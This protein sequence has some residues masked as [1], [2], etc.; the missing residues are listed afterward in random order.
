MHRAAG[1]NPGRSQRYT[2]RRQG[3]KRESVGSQWTDCFRSRS[4]HRRLRGKARHRQNRC[5]RTHPSDNA[6]PVVGDIDGSDGIDSH[7]IGPGKRSLGGRPS[8][9]AI[10]SVHRTGNGSDRSAGIDPSDPVVVRVRNLQVPGSVD[11]YPARL[12]EPRLGGRAPVTAIASVSRAGDRRDDA[13]RID[14]ADAVVPR[15][16]YIQIPCR[17]RGQAVDR[18]QPGSPPGPRD[19]RSVAS[20]SLS[21]SSMGTR[22]QVG[23]ST[24]QARDRRLGARA[25]WP[26]Q[27]PVELRFEMPSITNPHAVRPTCPDGG[28]SRRI[29]LTDSILSTYKFS[30]GNSVS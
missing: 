8:V 3:P 28:E 21:I 14:L 15:V 26:G 16:G 22:T 25:G 12:V 20:P 10:A 19:P 29:F 13:V 11:R 24:M 9:S 6:V 5:V 18:C 27:N 1:W 4:A 7:C 30:C 2:T 23:E 17:I